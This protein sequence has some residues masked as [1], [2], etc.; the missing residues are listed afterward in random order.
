[1]YDV[2]ICRVDFSSTKPSAILNGTTKIKSNHV[3]LD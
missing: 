2:A 3:D 1:M